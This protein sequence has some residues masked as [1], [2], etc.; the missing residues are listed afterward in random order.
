VLRRAG[1]NRY[2]VEIANLRDQD[3]WVH[4]DRPEAAETKAA[5]I[6]PPSWP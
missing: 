3:T 6:W 1:L 4:P 5:M 2:L